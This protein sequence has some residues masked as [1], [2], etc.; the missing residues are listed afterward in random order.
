V[1]G[2][3]VKPDATLIEEARECHLSGREP[4]HPVR[5]VER[6]RET[7]VRYRQLLKRLKAERAK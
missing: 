3:G 5:S 7:L 2:A 1:G 4:A 6:V